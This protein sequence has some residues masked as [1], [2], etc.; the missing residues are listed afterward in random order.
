M[1]AP[2]DLHSSWTNPAPDGLTAVSVTTPDG[3]AL[4]AARLRVPAARGTVVILGGRGDFLERYFETMRDFMARGLAVA[5]FD[6]R[7]TGGSQRMRDGSAVPVV[8]D[9]SRYDTDLETVM[10]QVVLPDCP[11]PYYVLAHSMGGPILIRAVA[12]HNWFER[13]MTTGPLLGFV[14]GTMPVT[15]GR[16]TLAGLR[17][18]GLT[19]LFLP[20]RRRG[21]LKTDAFEDNPLTSDEARWRRD[22]DTLEQFPA[23]ESPGPRIGWIHAA[24]RATAR[25]QRQAPRMQLTCPVMA[26]AAGMERLVDNRALMQLATRLHGLAVVVIPSARH[27]ILME[28]DEVRAQFWAAF[29]AFT[30][31][32]PPADQGIAA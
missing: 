14:P 1:S 20:G 13:V 2:S 18:A 31:L 27:E 32:S 29:D 26:V 25:L 5:T 21:S 3:V 22:F 7:G 15:L 4:R 24:E 30:G 12:R 17:F 23:L 19:G 6:W 10:K 11:P 9:F 8:T 28:A 16:L